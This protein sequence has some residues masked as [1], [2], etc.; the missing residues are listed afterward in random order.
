MTDPKTTKKLA[1]ASLKEAKKRAA[2]ESPPAPPDRAQKRPAGGPTPAERSAAAAERQ[3][4]LQ[5]LRVIIALGAM[6]LALVTLL[7][8]TRPWTWLED[9]NADRAG[10]AGA[11]TRG[12]A[13]EP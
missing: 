6:I 7:L 10:E 3:V 9:A 12:K 11:P 4:R 13:T 2:A 8:T 1:K 5:R